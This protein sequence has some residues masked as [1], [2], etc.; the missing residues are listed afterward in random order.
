MRDDPYAPLFELGKVIPHTAPLPAPLRS[1]LEAY[2]SDN[3]AELWCWIFRNDSSR[4]DSSVFSSFG[5]V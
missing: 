5:T 2:M 1:A 4:E 3:G